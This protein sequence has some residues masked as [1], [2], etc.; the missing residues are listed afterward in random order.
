LEKDNYHDAGF[1]A[2][3]TE[4]ANPNA[5]GS[6]DRRVDARD[7]DNGPTGQVGERV[8]SAPPDQAQTA[9]PQL[10]IH[11]P[12]ADRQL[13]DSFA[14]MD[15]NGESQRPAASAANRSPQATQP[16]GL[17]AQLEAAHRLRDQITLDEL[18][19]MLDGDGS[20]NPGSDNR[21][22][23][24]E[25]QIAS[26][27]AQQLETIAVGAGRERSGEAGASAQP[28]PEDI[29]AARGQKRGV[30]ALSADENA[31]KRPRL[32][33]V[34]ANTEQATVPPAA[35]GNNLGHAQVDAP[36]G[37]AV[38]AQGADRSG[39]IS[40]PVANAARAREP[41]TSNF[42]TDN[43]FQSGRLSKEGLTRLVADA[44]AAAAAGR[45]ENTGQNAPGSSAATT[46]GG[47][48]SDAQ[49]NSAYDNAARSHP[50]RFQQS[51]GHTADKGRTE[52]AQPHEASV[53]SHDWPSD[54]ALIA[55]AERAE[56]AYD[57]RQNPRPEAE[58]MEI[59]PDNSGDARRGQKRA[60]TDAPEQEPRAKAARADETELDITENH[61]RGRKRAAESDGEQGEAKRARVGNEGNGAVIT[62]ISGPARIASVAHMTDNDARSSSSGDRADHPNSG[63]GEASRQS[64]VA[65]FN[66]PENQQGLSSNTG[67]A[68]SSQ[69]SHVSATDD[70]S[71]VAQRPVTL[72]ASLFSGQ[73]QLTMETL[74][75]ASPSPAVH[76]E[77]SQDHISSF[78]SSGQE[79]A[80]GSENSARRDG[81]AN[82]SESSPVMDTDQRSSGASQHSGQSPVAA[83]NIPEN[84]QGLSSYDGNSSE[85]SHVSGTDDE[86]SASSAGQ[87]SP[88]TNRPSRQ[89][90]AAQAQN[91]R[92]DTMAANTAPQPDPRGRMGHL[93]NLEPVTSRQASAN[94]STRRNVPEQRIA[95][96]R[97]EAG[98]SA[99][100]L[101]ERS[102]N[103]SNGR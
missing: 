48:I 24:I 11:D 102:R 39:S 42:S 85:R 25:T 30:D 101:E 28:T 34:N 29:E 12:D 83:F 32:D 40:V 21:L 84:Q 93:P 59:E 78:G 3:F 37:A 38:H 20:Y 76:G 77:L 90:D 33:G 81:A 73:R 23:R 35:D 64:P 27:N 60:A 62:D 43:P 8:A 75:D 54:D 88:A 50:E 41:A 10:D 45:F 36:D 2:D 17:E 95:S 22:E 86:R 91:S 4:T 47:G 15:L 80:P 53:Q 44:G 51:A 26:L 61:I 103:A 99:R 89:E 68:S 7:S 74:R 57:Q 13:Q 56:R 94:S 82:R 87:R 100:R 5:T 71:S 1:G 63:N 97:E 69:R 14:N 9:S 58:R 19:K 67:D 49:M 52:N 98:S 31:A 18:T 16:T 66:I 65:A 79:S 46:Y 92:R 55:A 70:E 6:L 72:S 96:S